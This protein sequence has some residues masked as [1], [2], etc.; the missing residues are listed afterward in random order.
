MI[1]ALTDL[2]ARARRSGGNRAN[3]GAP[4]MKGKIGS[5]G[6]L[7]PY[8][9]SKLTKVE[10]VLSSIRAVPS[11]LLFPLHSYLWTA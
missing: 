3:G 11:H 2:R 10:Y 9:D 7:P 4:N 1:G 5:G 8:R 6:L